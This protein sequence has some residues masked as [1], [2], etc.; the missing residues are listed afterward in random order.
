MMI[1]QSAEV[2]MSFSTYL[3]TTGKLKLQLVEQ[4]L[5]NEIVC[6]HFAFESKSLSYICL[7]SLNIFLPYIYLEERQELIKLA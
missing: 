2:V 5:S 6:V 1:D 3:P 7:V 4:P